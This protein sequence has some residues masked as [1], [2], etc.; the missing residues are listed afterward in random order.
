MIIELRSTSM[1]ITISG[2]IGSGKSTCGKLLKDQLGYNYLSTGDIQRR[3]AAEMG[4]TTLE[5]N[6]LSEHDKSIDKKIDDHTRALADSDESYIVDSRLAWHFIP[7]SYKVF[8][9]CKDDIAAQRIFHDDNRISDEHTESI[10]QLLDKIKDRR[11]SEKRRFLSLYGI[12]FED[13]SN[14]DQIVDSSFFRPQVIVD[15]IKDGIK[16]FG[17]D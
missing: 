9:R 4:I 10:M 17:E 13:L 14:Y 1:I 8:L 3:I 7:T 2:D 12:D 6:L 15:F 5:L 11:Q 16:F